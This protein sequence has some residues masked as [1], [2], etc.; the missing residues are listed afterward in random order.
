MLVSWTPL[1]LRF[2]RVPRGLMSN[3]NGSK[4]TW[5]QLYEAA[6]LETDPE[7]LIELI[8][9]VEDTLVLRQQELAGSQISTANLAR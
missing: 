8:A 5:Q 9:A 4:A 2:S 6:A 7:K 3:S 1:N